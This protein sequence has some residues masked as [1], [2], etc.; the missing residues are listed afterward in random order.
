[1]AKMSRHELRVVIG[2]VVAVVWL[3]MS[4]GTLFVRDYTA[5]SVVT[6]VMVIVAGFLFA[7]TNGD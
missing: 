6:P 4:I 5:L 7:K 2:L 1:M 3:T